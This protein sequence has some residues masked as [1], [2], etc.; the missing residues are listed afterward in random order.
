V[1]P[2]AAMHYV[3]HPDLLGPV[4][5]QKLVENLN[6]ASI[7]RA[8]SSDLGRTGRGTTEQL[9]PGTDEYVSAELTT[10]R[11]VVA[12]L[13]Y[14]VTAGVFALPDPARLTPQVFPVWMTGSV[15]APP[16][17]RPHVDNKDG[18]SPLVTAV[19]YAQISDT[20]GGEI[21]IG[22]GPDQ[23][24]MSPAEDDLLA[25]PGNTLHVVND[26]RAGRRLSV[27][28]NFYLA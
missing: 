13:C 20:D 1:T 18:V 11:Q 23:I 25:F 21:V 24:V 8:R 4:R 19:Y 27:V 15:E 10:L 28:C 7:K 12:S 16:N 22:V 14:Q 9:I 2:P 26:L 5:R 17:Q 3:R 6:R